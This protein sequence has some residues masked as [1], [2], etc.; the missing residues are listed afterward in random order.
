[1]IKTYFFFLLGGVGGFYGAEARLVPGD[2]VLQR[3]KQ[4]L[5]MAGRGNDA[6]A[7]LG[8][9]R[10]RLDKDEIKNDLVLRMPYHGKI[11]IHTL[12]GLLINFN[13]YLGLL[14]LF[15]EASCVYTSA[16]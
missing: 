14:F 1:M 3:S 13:L 8:L 10:L 6:G 9:G 7:H 4:P 5:G 16:R 2:V 11:Y 12:G 15:H